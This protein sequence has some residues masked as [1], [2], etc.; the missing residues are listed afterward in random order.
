MF[1]SIFSYVCV[2]IHISIHLYNTFIVNIDKTV[3]IYFVHNMY[4][5]NRGHAEYM[6]IF[7]YIVYTVSVFEYSNYIWFT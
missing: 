2:R 1:R 6:Y 7:F 3:N 4:I 5:Y